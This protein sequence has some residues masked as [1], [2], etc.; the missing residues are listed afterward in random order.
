MV[1]LLEREGEEVVLTKARLQNRESM[2]KELDE[3]KPTR[4]LNI[5]YFFF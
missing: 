4:V 1:A 3:V 2:E 5:G